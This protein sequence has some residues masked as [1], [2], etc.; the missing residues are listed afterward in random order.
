RFGFARARHREN[1][2]KP[3]QHARKYANARKSK[4]VTSDAF[5]VSVR[6]RA[7]RVEGHER[8]ENLA[9]PL[10]T[11]C[12]DAQAAGWASRSA[13][14]NA[15]LIAICESL[16]VSA[17]QCSA[18]LVVMRLFQSIKSSGPRH[19]ASADHASIAS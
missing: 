19:A 4:I 12:V 18:I 1:W 8:S 16:V 11:R 10:G 3:I 13:G 6:A 15:I 2:P 5:M 9:L 17:E 7:K 14:R